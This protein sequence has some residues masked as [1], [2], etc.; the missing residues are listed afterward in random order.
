MATAC[1]AIE[2]VLKGDIA[3]VLKQAISQ[4]ASN[5]IEI[6]G[7][8]THGSINVKDHPV[9][10][11]YTFDDKTKKLTIKMSKDSIFIPCDTIKNALLK[12]FQGK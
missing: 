10:G 2:V 9:T 1:P 11:T 12:F 3:T 5:G 4:G 6:K 8:T 7:D